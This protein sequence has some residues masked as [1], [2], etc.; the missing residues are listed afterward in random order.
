MAMGT[1]G[2]QRA[3]VELARISGIPHD[4]VM[5]TWH[6]DIPAGS[7][8]DATTIETALRTLYS[9]ISTKFASNL[10]GAMTIAWYN[11]TTLPAGPPWR[12]VVMTPIGPGTGNPL[13]DN[14]A[15]VISF[16]ADLTGIPEFAPGTRPRQSRRGRV[17]LGPLDSATVVT[18]SPNHRPRVDPALLTTLKTQLTTFLSTMTDSSGVHWQVYSPKGHTIHP[19]VGGWVDNRFDSVRRRQEDATSR[20][21]W[22]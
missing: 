20:T 3:V 14:D 2:I 5:N 16:H 13:P 4:T 11:L 18:D 22:P 15:I 8:T 10:S 6:F 19:V 12:T 7:S 21:L 9:S 17:Y 1:G